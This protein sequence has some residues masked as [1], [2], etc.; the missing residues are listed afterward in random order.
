NKKDYKKQTYI[1]PDQI[2]QIPSSITNETLACEV[3]EKNYKITSQELEFYK[4]L[5]LPIPHSCYLCRH[6]TRMAK[7]N[8]RKLWEKSCAK[9]GIKTQ[10]TYPPENPSPILCEKCYLEHVG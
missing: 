8:P 1:I 7:K 6:K 10:T 5:N 3:C 9:C 4:K 2:T